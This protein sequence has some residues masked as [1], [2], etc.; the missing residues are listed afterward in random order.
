[1]LQQ[2]A[3]LRGVATVTFQFGDDLSLLRD[4]ALALSDVPSRQGQV[5][6]D[7]GTVWHLHLLPEGVGLD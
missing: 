1:L 5:V 2:C 4:I 7:H 3:S 6:A